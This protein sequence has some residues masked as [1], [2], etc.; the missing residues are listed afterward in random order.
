MHA[1][2]HD[3]AL[4][5]FEKRR[6][7]GAGSLPERMISRWRLKTGGGGIQTSSVVFRLPSSLEDTHQIARM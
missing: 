2:T 5:W 3:M 1:G 6:P 7:N 4:I